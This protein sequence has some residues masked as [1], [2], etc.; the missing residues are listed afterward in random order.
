MMV[1]LYAI[2]CTDAIA[3]LLTVRV[4]QASKAAS[5]VGIKTSLSV[6]D[7]HIVVV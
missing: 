5:Q 3:K 1:E 2:S 4:Q 7:Y 6:V